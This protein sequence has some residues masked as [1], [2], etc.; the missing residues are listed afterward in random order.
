[1]NGSRPEPTPHAL[2]RGARVLVTG[3]AGFIGASVSRALRQRG[4]P[5]DC[6]VVPRSRT[7][8]LRVAEH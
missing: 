7:C 5:D 6:L 4:V 1:M 3:G 8:D 2:W